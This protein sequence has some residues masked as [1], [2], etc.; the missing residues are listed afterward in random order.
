MTYYTLEDAQIQLRE[1]ISSA[2]QGKQIIIK[3][4]ADEL[5]LMV[6]VKR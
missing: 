3:I 6:V 4:D 2:L 5:Q 1:L